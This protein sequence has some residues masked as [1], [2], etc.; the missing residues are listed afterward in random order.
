[1]PHTWEEEKKRSKKGFLDSVHKKMSPSGEKR[2]IK[3]KMSGKDVYQ[4]SQ[5]DMNAITKKKIQE[6]RNRGEKNWSRFKKK[7]MDLFDL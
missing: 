3:Y 4:L 7:F 1:M 6:Q 5:K 2:S